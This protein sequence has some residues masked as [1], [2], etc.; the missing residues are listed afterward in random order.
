[1]KKSFPEWLNFHGALKQ[2]LD[3]LEGGGV[4][5]MWIDQSRWEWHAEDNLVGV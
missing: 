5:F 3:G 1:M 2:K 4:K